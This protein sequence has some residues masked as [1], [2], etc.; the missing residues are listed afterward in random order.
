MK[1]P[2]IAGLFIF[3]SGSDFEVI[4]QLLG[5]RHQLELGELGQTVLVGRVGFATDQ[6]RQVLTGCRGDAEAI[7]GDELAGHG[8]FH[9][10]HFLQRGFE[11]RKTTLK[12]WS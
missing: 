11:I 6:R 10:G 2:R 1:K 8:F 12:N 4:V 3:K 5:N 9:V 7:L